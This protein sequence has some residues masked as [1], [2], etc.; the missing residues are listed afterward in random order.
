MKKKKSK[1]SIAHLILF[2]SAMFAAY[3]FGLVGGF[4]EGRDTREI[5]PGGLVAGLIV[6]I[7][8]AVA[9]SRLGSVKGKT[10]T[11]QARMSVFA[12][13]AL[14]PLMVSPVIYYM[15]PDTVNT[16]IRI[17]LSIGWPLLPDIAIVA[18]GAV[19]GASLVSLGASGSVA[20]PRSKRR[21]SVA[22]ATKLYR[23]VCGFETENRN[24]YS[25]HTGQCEP[26]KL[27]KD[28]EQLIP[29]DLEMKG[30]E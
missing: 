4:I 16:F 28:K 9:S 30:S 3:N 2:L 17:L 6:N 26:Y 24:R 11:L 10:R 7:S 19:A 13:L 18:A 23:C 8:L 27:S 5:S 22:I 20:Q 12:M 14:A 29:V 1:L 21:P 15:I 25:G